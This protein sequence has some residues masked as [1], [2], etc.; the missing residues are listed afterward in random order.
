MVKQKKPK[1]YYKIE[2]QI[3][4]KYDDYEDFYDIR[5]EYILQN[6]LDSD[7][8][9]DL[10][11]YYTW[12]YGDGNYEF[13]RCETYTPRDRN[14]DRVKYITKNQVWQGFYHKYKNGQELSVDYL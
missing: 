1:E 6:E 4:K 13:I 12:L 9:N 5:E 10:I 14:I 8:M 7:L 3:E 11:S 2:I